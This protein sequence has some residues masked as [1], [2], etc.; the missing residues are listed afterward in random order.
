VWPPTAVVVDTSVSL[1]T[2]Q[3]R[4]GLFIPPVEA[5]EATGAKTVAEGNEV[6][7]LLP[8]WAYASWFG[9]VMAASLEYEQLD[10]SR[11]ICP[12]VERQTKWAVIAF[13]SLNNYDAIIHVPVSTTPSPSSTLS[14]S[15]NSSHVTRTRS[16][17]N[18]DSA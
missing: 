4:N 2:H 11:D 8:H 13:H 5:I 6:T 1:D 7:L 10:A 17:P 14:P 15:R 3:R 16:S 12:P 18:S 9:T